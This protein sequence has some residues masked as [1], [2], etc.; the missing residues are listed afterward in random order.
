MAGKACSA[1]QVKGSKDSKNRF[2]AR[3]IVKYKLF[4]INS[5]GANPSLFPI[6]WLCLKISGFRNMVK[7]SVKQ[8]NEVRH[9]T[10]QSRR[11]HDKHGN[12]PKERW[13]RFVLVVIS[14]RMLSA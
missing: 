8:W 6:L 4:I 5:L 1:K 9:R 7:Q 2:G 14:S 3:C 13:H 12:V 11:V 10:R